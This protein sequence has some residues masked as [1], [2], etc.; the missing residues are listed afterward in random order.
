MT[1]LDTFNQNYPRFSSDAEI[2][3]I[4]DSLEFVANEGWKLMPQYIFNNETAE[5]KHHTDQVTSS[6]PGTAVSVAIV[7]ILVLQNCI[8]AL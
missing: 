7:E 2:D 5:W 6:N 4:L 1:S 8:K 3:F